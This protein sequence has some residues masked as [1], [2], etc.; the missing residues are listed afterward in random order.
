MTELTKITRNTPSYKLADAVA[1]LLAA[2]DATNDE[3]REASGVGHNT[4]YRARVFLSGEIIL[5][6]NHERIHRKALLR[7]AAVVDELIKERQNGTATSPARSVPRQVAAADTNGVGAVGEALVEAAK[8]KT[9]ELS[10]AAHENEAAETE[11]PGP[12]RWGVHGVG[13]PPAPMVLFQTQN[14]AMD[15]AG[16][17]AGKQGRCYRICH[18]VGEARP[19][20][21]QATVTMF[22]GEG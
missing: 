20:Q 3:L 19:P 13:T 4:L 8:A 5:A 15:Y 18:I 17:M 1:A 14:E 12:S 16:R 21:Q 22:E 9:E 6:T 7:G 2:P 11:E 10:E